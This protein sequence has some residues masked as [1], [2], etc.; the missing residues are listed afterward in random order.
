MPPPFRPLPAAVGAGTWGDYTVSSDVFLDKTETAAL[1]GRINNVGYGYGII[2]KGYILR[3][4]G[5]GKLVLSVIRGK[6]DKKALVGDAEQ[7]AMIRAGVDSGEGGEKLLGTAKVSHASGKWHT[8][9]L[10]FKGDQITAII[11]G[12][13]AITATDGAYATGMAG[14]LAG[15][16][17]AHESRPYFDNFSVAPDPYRSPLRQPPLIAKPMYP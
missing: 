11:D 15:R 12:R 16:A 6:L 5:D 1:L 13:A 8:V 2:P 10:R 17:G 9:K 3:L 14:L 7:Q 4:T